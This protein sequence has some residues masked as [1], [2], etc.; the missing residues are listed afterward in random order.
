MLLRLLLFLL[1]FMRMMTMTITIQH[2]C[3]IRECDEIVMPSN[4]SI[5]QVVYEQDE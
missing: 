4:R 2:A 1:L 3:E 5:G